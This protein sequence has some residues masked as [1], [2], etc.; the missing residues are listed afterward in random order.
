MFS[1]RIIKEAL[2]TGNVKKK[3]TGKWV[4]DPITKTIPEEKQIENATSP[5]LFI[6]DG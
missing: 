1:E 6:P 2:T 4:C 5:I 3:E